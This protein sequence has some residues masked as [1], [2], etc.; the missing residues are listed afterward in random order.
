MYFDDYFKK[1]HSIVNLGNKNVTSKE[2]FLQKMRDD[3][4]KEKEQQILSKNK[5]IIKNFL[6]KHFTSSKFSENS[7][8]ISNLNSISIFIEQNI[9][10]FDSTKKEQIAIKTLEKTIHEINRFLSCKMITLQTK[11]QIGKSISFLLSFLTYQQIKYVFVTNKLYLQMLY[12]L[13]KIGTQ[14]VYVSIKN[15]YLIDKNQMI[16]FPFLALII[17]YL[18]S[19]ERNC[20]I[21]CLAKNVSYIY[22]LQFILENYNKILTKEDLE[23]FLSFCDLLAGVIISKRNCILNN[24][25]NKDNT[26]VIITSFLRKLQHVCLLQ[27]NVDILNICTNFYYLS[28]IFNESTSEQIISGMNQKLQMKLF[29]LLATQLKQG[30]H[31]NNNV[32][33]SNSLN[34]HYVFFIALFK[35]LTNITSLGGMNRANILKQI[36]IFLEHLFKNTSEVSEKNILLLIYHSAKLIEFLY[37]SNY[38]KSDYPSILDHIVNKIAIKNTPDLSQRIFT[39]SVDLLKQEFPSL[40]INNRNIMMFNNTINIVS[41]RETTLKQFEIISFFLLTQINYKSNYFFLEFKTTKEI[42]QNLPFNYYYL[43]IY[44]KYLISTFNDLITKTNIDELENLS[45]NMLIKCLKSLYLLDGEINFTYNREQFW[46]NL[47]LVSK[48]T[49]TNSVALLEKMKLMPFIFPLKIRLDIT[50]N[51]LRKIKDNYK[52]SLPHSINRHNFYPHDDYEMYEDEQMGG[53]QSIVMPRDS[54]FESSMSFYLQNLLKPYSKWNIVFVDK[55]GNKEDGVDSGGLYK[56]FMGKLS[57]EAFSDKMKLFIESESGFLIPNK[58]SYK[59][60]NKHLLMFE[61]LGF[62]TAKAILDDIKLYPNLSP[63]FLNNIL[64]IENSFTD[65][66]GYDSELYKNLVALKQYEGDVENDFGLSFAISEENAYGKIQ[67]KN[68]IENG[69]NIPV[70]NNNRLLYIQK[71]TEYKLNFQFKEQCLNF[72]NGMQKVLDMEILKLFTG[73]EMRQLIYGFDKDAF[74]VLDMR[75]NISYVGWDMNNKADLNVLDNFFRILDEFDDKEK[76][77]FLFFCTSLKRL[78]I[79]GFSKLR[80]RFVLAKAHKEVPT[81]STCV[82]MLKLPCLP[83]H[84]LKEILRYVIN[85]DAGFYYA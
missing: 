70:T 2:A 72:R 27:D 58:E 25:F 5:L 66:K 36:N 69:V 28:F 76:E 3:D 19:K 16:L 29:N 8:L 79:G 56:E 24:K 49:K 35:N 82:N 6:H 61:F 23:L 48:V 32:L 64:Q 45:Q 51:E 71:I 7:K 78:P 31:I 46:N 20:V 9:N 80:P 39:Y 53:V 37:L 73:D 74:D 26:N 21:N 77:K 40:Q 22:I 10:S 1:E 60:S 52:L 75:Q 57:E 50:T 41:S 44:S 11:I 14:Q 38:E 55:F 13:I 65:L 47:E 30:L 84:K 83:Y 54:L 67:S 63:I 17:Q 62:I 15:D 81:S 68:L 34:S 43:N 12:M 42:Y 85:A 4:K 33:R 18:H 59:I